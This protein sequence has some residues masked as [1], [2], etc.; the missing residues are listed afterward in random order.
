MQITRSPADTIKGP[1]DWFTRDVY[2]DS[3]AGAP[4]PSRVTANLV[5][6]MPG[7]RTNWHRHPLSQTVFGT[8]GV[9]LCQRRGGLIEVIRPGGRVLFEADEQHWHGAASNR[10][11]VHLAINET[12]DHHDVA[13]WL[14]PVSD[15][16]Y[17]ATVLTNA[18]RPQGQS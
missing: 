13:H 8:E 10:L 15:A 1:G 3:V 18:L 11:M 17:T 5:H 4:A 9:G 14:E 2:L 12:D 16:E 6:F 7:A